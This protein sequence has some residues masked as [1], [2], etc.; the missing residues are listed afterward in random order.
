MKMQLTVTNHAE[1]AEKDRAYWRERSP[2]ERLDAV[3]LLR[4][5]A[6][7][8]LYEYPSRLRKVISVTR[9]NPRDIEETQ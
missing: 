3:E 7:K 9:R 4:I 2:E 8:F 6:G 1:Q 5:E